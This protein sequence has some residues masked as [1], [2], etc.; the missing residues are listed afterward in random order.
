MNNTPSLDSTAHDRVVSFPELKSSWGIRFSRVHLGRLEK[1]GQF[2][3]RLSLG[4]GTV[5]WL[6]SEL[7]QYLAN[8]AAARAVGG[9]E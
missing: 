9:A 7:A 8:H 5:G 6:A 1:A 4:H 3:R 2:P